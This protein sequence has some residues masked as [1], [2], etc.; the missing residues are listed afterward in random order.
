MKILVTGATG[1]IGNAF[2]QALIAERTDYDVY[3]AVRKSSNIEDLEKFNVKFI[4]FDLTDFTTFGSAVEGMDIVVH[5]AS[6]Y[7]NWNRA[8][9]DILFSRNVV[10]TQK[11]AEACLDGQIQHFVYCSTTE[12]LGKV[13]NGTEESDYNPDEIYGKTKMEAEKILIEMQ[14]RRGFPLTIA[15]P[16]GVIG[17]GD[18]FPF[19]DLILAVEKK[20]ILLPKFLPGSGKGTIHWTDI[21]DIVQ[22]FIKIIEKPEK[23]I[24]QIYNLASNQAQTWNEVVK[25][26]CNSL[27]LKSSTY[28]IPVFLARIGVPLFRVY[29]KIRGVKNFILYPN[30]VKKL[31]TSRS[32]INSKAKKELGFNPTV[33]FGSS[34]H[35]AVSWLKKQGLLTQRN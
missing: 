27:G 1:F 8:P 10:A 7:K 26:I 13:I 24:G 34:V 19:T 32:Y 2:V 33:D 23:S 28:H 12:A 17:F 20:L 6:P 11:L 15:R 3:S 31:Q 30:A 29:Y 35:N 9:E 14:E 5:F 25:T 4:D 21:E 18:C 22:G 16:T